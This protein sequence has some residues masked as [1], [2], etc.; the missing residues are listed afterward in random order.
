MSIED[1]CVRES[2][3]VLFE[4]R[5]ASVFFVALCF[6][7]PAAPTLLQIHPA[8]HNK[9]KSPCHHDI[10]AARAVTVTLACKGEMVIHFIHKLGLELLVLRSPPAC[11]RRPTPLASRTRIH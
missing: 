5:Y 8:N 3:W 9:Q 1:S 10:A 4:C 7:P 2:D 11:L 6:N